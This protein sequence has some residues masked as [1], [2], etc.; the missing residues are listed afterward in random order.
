[1]YI[2]KLSSDRI[3][4]VFTGM[5]LIQSLKEQETKYEHKYN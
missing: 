2:G 3:L 4:Q 1:M 5:K